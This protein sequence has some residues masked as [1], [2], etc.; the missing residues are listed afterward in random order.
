M[1]ST[2]RLIAVGGTSAAGSPERRAM[3]GLWWRH[4]GVCIVIACA[5]LAVMRWWSWAWAPAS[6]VAI[7]YLMYASLEMA[8]SR[9][10]A[11]RDSLTSGP[12]PATRAV[13]VE[14]ERIGT[15]IVFTLL[16]GIWAMGMVVAAL[17]L[18]SSVLGIGT[19]VAF[20]MVVFVGLPTWAAVV[21]DSIPQDRR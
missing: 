16:A 4:S 21:G 6:V 10:R 18:D 14:R 19:A 8:A 13:L 9:S 2:R 1:Q 5:M 20:G 7:L 3:R 12:R 17:V 11:L 15:R